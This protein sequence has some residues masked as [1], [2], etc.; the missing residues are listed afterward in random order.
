[1]IPGFSSDFLSKG[2]EQ[3]SMARLKK[4]MTIMD[5]MNDEGNISY[6][7][8]LFILA[9]DSLSKQCSLTARTNRFTLFTNCPHLVDIAV[10]V[11]ETSFIES[12][13]S[14]DE[15]KFCSREVWYFVVV[16]VFLLTLFVT[17]RVLCPGF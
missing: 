1:M 4:L 5:S 8:V 16:L 2:N 13:R 11:R 12:L 9:K 3:E 15:Y 10:V 14:E 6:V 17:F 7:I